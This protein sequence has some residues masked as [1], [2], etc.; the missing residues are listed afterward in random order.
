MRIAI[1]FS[2]L[3]M[4]ALPGGCRQNVL[5]ANDYMQWIRN[6]DNGLHTDK[7]MGK[8]AFDLQYKT[9]E[10]LALQNE[11]T[12]QLTEKRMAEAR[13]RF[14]DLEQ[15]TFRI[16]TKDKSDVLEQD[17]D[18]GRRLEYF[19][20]YAQ[21]DLALIRGNDTLPC[22]EYSYERTYGLSPEV[23]LVVGFKRSNTT[24]EPDRT[25]VFNDQVLGVGPVKL[26]ID[27][28]S[29]TQLPALRYEN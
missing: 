3:I 19:V 13:S 28:T 21:N 14:E 11:G 18:N 22:I 17:E 16:S 23:T 29:F 4:A 26:T 10:Y 9:P 8:Y 6:K 15:Y 2:I 25:F 20:T 7:S 27:K 24:D 1:Y 5:P 12:D